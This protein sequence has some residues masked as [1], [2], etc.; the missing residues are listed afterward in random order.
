MK[1]VTEWMYREKNRGTKNE[2]CL[3]MGLASSVVIIISAVYPSRALVLHHY[4]DHIFFYYGHSVWLISVSS[5]SFIHCVYFLV[6]DLAS[7]SEDVSSWPI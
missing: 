4:C 6:T 1:A 3:C 2:T 5:H 7:R